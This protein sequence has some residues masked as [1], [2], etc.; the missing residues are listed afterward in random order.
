MAPFDVH[1]KNGK[2]QPFRHIARRVCCFEERIKEKDTKNCIS[3]SS[4]KNPLA[5][6]QQFSKA[7]TDDKKREKLLMG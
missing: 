7:F 4:H 1:L 3:S 6:C 2:S 5:F